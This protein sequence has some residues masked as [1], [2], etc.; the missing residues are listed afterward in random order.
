LA[1]S[2]NLF[3]HLTVLGNLKLAQS[4]ARGRNGAGLPQ[5]GSL[6]GELGLDAWAE[7]WPAQ[8]SGG[9]RVRASLAVA[10]ANAPAVILADEPT[11]ELDE[12]TEA[13]ILDILRR[14]AASGSAILVASHSQAVTRAAD[15]T[16]H[17]EDGQLS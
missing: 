15:R 1:Q 17:L 14:R 13:Q 10:M 16:L 3:P 11:G 4:L 7:A 9:E 8:L 2:G 12:A 5:P 6:L